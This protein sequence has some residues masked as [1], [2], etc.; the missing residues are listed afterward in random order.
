VAV[1]L[2][3][4]Q[5]VEHRHQELA[6]GDFQDEQDKIGVFRTVKLESSAP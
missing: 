2:E 1:R 6:A 5:R 3:E 4:R